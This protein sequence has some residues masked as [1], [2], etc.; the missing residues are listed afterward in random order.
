MDPREVAA[1]WESNAETWTSHARKGYDVYR[2]AL[3]TPAFLDLLPPVDGLSGLDVGCGEGANT[4]QLAQRG[5]RMTAVDIAPTFIRHAQAT[6]DAEPLGIC[7][8]VGDGM[9]LPFPE[10]SFDF[11]TAI[12]SLMDMPDPGLAVGEAARVIRPGG[13]L[14][15]SILHPCF[16]PP[17]RRVL[18]DAGGRTTGVVLGRYF[19]GV[20]GELDIWHFH[21]APAEERAKVDPFR[22][23]RFHRTLSQWVEFL[24]AAGLA[25]EKFAEPSASAELAAQVH[26]VEDTRVVPLF[27]QVRAR[28][29]K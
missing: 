14:Q 16:S 28:K 21:T 17:Q 20:D 22:T 25:I 5:A 15:F 4:R 2:D 8:Q 9:A 3:N 11:V 29:S 18:R 12:M 7:Y 26:E 19:D 27:L 24:V 10:R 23:P 6:E 13:F 1:L